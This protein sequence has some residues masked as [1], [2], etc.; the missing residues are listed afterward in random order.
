MNTET[1]SHPR[2][3]YAGVFVS[4]FVLT[5]TE[6]FVAN[7]PITKTMIVISLVFLAIVKASLVAMFYMHL[8]Y[9]KILLAVLALAPLVFSLIL[10]IGIGQDIG[11]P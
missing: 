10:T 8:R 5:V 11:H 7:L 3:N 1:H 9:E 6:I 2:P 4:L